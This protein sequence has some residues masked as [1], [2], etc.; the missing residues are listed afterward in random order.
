MLTWFVEIKLLMNDRIWDAMRCGQHPENPR[1]LKEGTFLSVSLWFRA[2]WRCYITRDM[3]S[4]PIGLS[5]PTSSIDRLM[6][7]IR[8]HSGRHSASDTTT[9]RRIIF[10]MQ[11]ASRTWEECSVGCQCTQNPTIS[12]IVSSLSV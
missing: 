2:V 3:P 1:E 9:Y 10:C 7:V 5:R 6:K 8:S 11:G 4:Y 12:S